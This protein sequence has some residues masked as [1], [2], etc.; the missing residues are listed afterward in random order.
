MGA[1]LREVRRVGLGSYESLL[2]WLGQRAS[3]VVC[4]KTRLHRHP[5]RVR[6][7]YRFQ[8]VADVF[9]GCVAIPSPIYRSYC[10]RSRLNLLAGVTVRQQAGLWYVN[11]QLTWDLGCWGIPGLNIMDRGIF[12]VA[13][14][15]T[16]SG[17][18]RTEAVV[19]LSRTILDGYQWGL[20]PV[21]ADALEDAGADDPAA[22][23]ILRK[24]VPNDVPA[25]LLGA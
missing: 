4:N 8:A 2:G 17:C 23:E 19:A 7:T 12:Y 13:R 16:P 5:D 24:G 11:G 6:L 25:K 9:P 21:L 20:C 14:D 18:H 22:L 10:T 3:K 15:Y 1:T